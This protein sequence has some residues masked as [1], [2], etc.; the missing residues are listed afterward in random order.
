M[1]SVEIQDKND[2]KENVEW[3]TPKSVC[4]KKDDSETGIVDPRVE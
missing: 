2:W 4:A 1:G 3:I